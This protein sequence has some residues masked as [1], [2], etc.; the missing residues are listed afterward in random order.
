MAASATTL[1]FVSPRVAASLLCGARY[2]CGEVVAL[3]SSDREEER[4]TSE[5][6]PRKPEDTTSLLLQN[7]NARSTPRSARGLSRSPALQ[8]Q[9]AKT[10]FHPGTRELRDSGCTSAPTTPPHP[11][12]TVCAI[13]CGNGRRVCAFAAYGFFYAFLLGYNMDTVVYPLLLGHRPLAIAVA[14]VLL[15]SP[16]LWCPLFYVAKGLLDA[17]FPVLAKEEPEDGLAVEGGA[18][19]AAST[20]ATSCGGGTGAFPARALLALAQKVRWAL[21]RTAEVVPAELRKYFCQN[22]WKDN[23]VVCAF[24]IPANY[25]IFAFPPLEYRTLAG[26]VL[27]SVWT[28]GWIVWKSCGDAAAAKHGG[29]HDRLTGR[30]EDDETFL[31]HVAEKDQASME[32]GEDVR[33]GPRPSPA[34]GTLREEDEGTPTTSAGEEQTRGNKIAHR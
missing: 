23:G 24:W 5:A 9:Q 34:E 13:V 18:S 8:D 11:S 25:V 22:F 12:P 16:F 3:V 21:S 2:A 20:P 15:Y 17:F 19:S 28:C 4:R 33:P 31:P 32:A 26:N 10:P 1:L 27:A 7:G 29:S 6:R 30:A 14:D